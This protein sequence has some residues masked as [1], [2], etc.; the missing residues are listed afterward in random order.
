MAKKKVLVASD[1]VSDADKQLSKFKTGRIAKED[2][3]PMVMKY[4][5]MKELN[6]K[7]RMPDNLASVMLVIIEKNLGSASW[8]RYSPDWKEEMRAKAQDHLLRYAHNFSPEKCEAGKDDP[9]NYF[10]MVAN[11]AFIQS[12]KKL[13]KHQS[14]IVMINHDVLYNEMQYN[15][16]AEEFGLEVNCFDPCVSNLDWGKSL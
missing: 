4:K 14:H 10:A 6:S 1:T 7:A 12:L 15:Q 5:A 3:L 16:F 8:R 2:L 13:K 9:Y 11:R